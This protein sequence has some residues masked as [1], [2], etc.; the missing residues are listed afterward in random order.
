M[1]KRGCLSEGN[2]RILIMAVCISLM[3][4]MAGA[5]F[6]IIYYHA[7][8]NMEFTEE[9][10]TRHMHFLEE[11]D[12]TPVTMDEFMAWRVENAIMP[13]RPIVITFDDN[14]IDTY[15]IAYPILK[16]LDFVAI[17]FV[18]TSSVGNVSPT[19]EYCDW[20][21]LIKMEEEGV[22]YS[23]S[24]A[25]THPSL[26]DLNRE[27]I[28]AEVVDSR[29]ILEDQKNRDVLHIAYPFGSYDETVIEE[30]EKAGYATGQTT[31][32]DFNYQD[33]PL[34][35]LNR[36]CMDGHIIGHTLEA[37]K[38]KLQWHDR[39]SPPSDEGWIIDNQD[40]NFSVMEGE[41]DVVDNA[42]GWES[43]YMQSSDDEGKVRWAAELDKGRYYRLYT[44]LPG[45]TESATGGQYSVYHKDGTE[46]FEAPLNQDVSSWFEL[47]V[48]YFD[49]EYPLKVTLSQQDGQNVIADA[50]W[51]KPCEVTFVSQWELY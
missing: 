33:T 40:A 47:G 46:S 28:E 9:M 3:M 35:E 15:N 51:F 25:H 13:L 30:V 7:H 12:F 36:L 8:P 22:F 43:T 26:A 1:K 2:K 5:Q 14:Y 44:W 16:E 32:E 31:R 24:H 21:T 4:L 50:L 48:F 18:I 41:W 38:T 37:F 20:D 23:E 49:E 42:E 10:F 11:E 34:Y 45:S 39:Q 6:P 19:I 17:N 29:Q 27:E